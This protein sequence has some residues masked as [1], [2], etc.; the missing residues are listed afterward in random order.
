MFLYCIKERISI[1]QHNQFHHHLLLVIDLS[2][3]SFRFLSMA[4]KGRISFAHLPSEGPLHDIKTFPLTEFLC[5]SVEVAEHKQHYSILLLRGLCNNIKF[6]SSSK[7]F[8]P[9]HI[10][11]EYSVQMYWK[12]E[13]RSLGLTFENESSTD[14]MAKSLE[15]LHGCIPVGVDKVIFGGDQLTCERATGI[16]ILN[17]IAHC[18]HY[19]IDTN[20]CT[21]LI[22][23]IMYI[24]SFYPTVQTEAIRSHSL[25]HCY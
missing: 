23:S 18:T 15:T 11:H 17:P 12:S 22:Y 24:V 16:K 9:R 10:I 3:L 13:E 7:K 21:I 8:V 19:V 1:V 6:L 2:F 5:S 14:G 4:F 20:T 25:K